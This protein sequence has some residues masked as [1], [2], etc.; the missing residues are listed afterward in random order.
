MKAWQLT[1][2]IPRHGTTRPTLEVLEDRY[3]LAASV[4]QAVVP[5]VTTPQATGTN[6]QA[7]L[8][9]S[10]P[11]L[12]QNGQAALSGPAA[13]GGQGAV[14]N[15]VFM[16]GAPASAALTAAATAT[17]ALTPLPVS[18]SPAVLASQSSVPQDLYQVRLVAGNSGEAAAT[19]TAVSAAISVPGVG[20]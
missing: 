7:A 6:T 10:F 20:T 4:V 8:A 11:V 15:L 3:L 16:Q 18:P 5:A 12:A 13:S 17:A 9:D 19:A 1:I 14:S 2:G